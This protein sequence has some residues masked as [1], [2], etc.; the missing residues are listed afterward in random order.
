M[1]PTT[2]CPFLDV[3]PPELRLSIYGYALQYDGTLQ[4][5]SHDR[6][7]AQLKLGLL[8]ASRQVH[9][10]AIGVFYNL[11]TFKVNYSRI[12]DCANASATFPESHAGLLGLLPRYRAPAFDAMRVCSLHITA[13]ASFDP[14]ERDRPGCAM[15]RR[16]GVGLIDYLLGLPKLRIVTI[17]FDFVFGL[18]L[19][20]RKLRL[21]HS[22]RETVWDLRAS[23][24]GS[25]F[26]TGT[27][28][29]IRLNVSALTR[30]WRCLAGVDDVGPEAEQLLGEEAMRHAMEYILFEGEVSGRVPR[31]LSPF[32]DADTEHG[33]PELRLKSAADGSKRL[34][35][36][37]VALTEVLSDIFLEHGGSESIDWVQLDGNAN[38]VNWMCKEGVS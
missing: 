6:K 26:L 4:K 28:K 12:C 33:L 1:S 20:A 16:S 21:A 37:T 15:C 19:L 38:Y 14:D 18:A 34:A 7:G 23:E 2:D 35:D 5:P 31:S 24:I 25:L 22:A 9:G 10:E 3:L 11:N 30:A 13:F 32:F 17:D 8:R 27:D 36:F 29:C